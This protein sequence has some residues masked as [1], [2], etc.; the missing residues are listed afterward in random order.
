V[1]VGKQLTTAQI[2]ELKEH[3]DHIPTSAHARDDI[4]GE[5]AGPDLLFGRQ[6]HATKQE[7]LAALPPRTEADQM[8]AAYFESMHSAPSKRSPLYS[9][10][11]TEHY[12]TFA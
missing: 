10:P 3:L 7:L 6:R 11:Y 1:R 2:S 4:S 5:I 9:L 12:S 8:I